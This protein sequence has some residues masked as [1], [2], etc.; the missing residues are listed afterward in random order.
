MTSRN[1]T[2]EAFPISEAPPAKAAARRRAFPADFA[3]PAAFRRRIWIFLA[4]LLALRLIAMA[5]LPLVD[6]TEARYAE[7]ARKMVETGNWITP[8]FDYG[9]PFWGK[10][11]LHTWLSALG[12][13]AF[14]IHA[15]AARLP[16][17]AVSL[18]ILALVH[19]WTARLLGPNRALA[20][21]AILSSMALFWGASAFVMTD[22][23]MVLGLVL[24]M[25]GFWRATQEEESAPLWGYAVFL[26][27]AMGLM[28]KGPVAIALVVVALVPWL[29]IRRA[30]GDLRRLPWAGGTLLLILLVVPWHLAA[31]IA[32]P[33]FLRYFLWGEHVQRFLVPGWSGDLYGSAHLRPKGWIWPMALMIALPWS[34]LAPA[35]ILRRRSRGLE[36]LAALPSGFASWLFCWILAPLIFFTPAGNILPAYALP[37]LPAAAILMAAAPGADL[38]QGLLRRLTALGLGLVGIAAVAV[39]LVSLAPE[40]L[41]LKSHEALAEAARPWL[42][43]DPLYV[44]GRR[45]FSAEFYTAGR[46]RSVK[47]EDLAALAAGPRPVAL[48]AP[49]GQAAQV[50]A[51]GFRPVGRFGRHELFVSGGETP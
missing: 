3:W 48:S 44:L 35:L 49:V 21:T 28:A 50:E 7:I 15:F 41:R 11:P 24:V 46:A 18:A 9:V 19:G 23:P 6:T 51:E 42:R 29:T 8:Q 31:E 43:E 47:P 32:T 40:T 37:A 34:L 13:E 5:G 39:G 20:A 14:G 38:P 2:G 17:L 45:S 4:V 33:G 27:L 10:P 36:G 16:V 12:M 22:M 1:L 30:W 26:G 25:V